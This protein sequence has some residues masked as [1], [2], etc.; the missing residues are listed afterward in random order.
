[1][2]ETGPVGDDE[3]KVEDVMANVE[4]EEVP[5]DALVEEGYVEEDPG[6]RAS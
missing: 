3:Q 1:M 2:S 4:V 6:E 5:D